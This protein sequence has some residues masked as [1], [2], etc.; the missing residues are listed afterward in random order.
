[1]SRTKS[2]DFYVENSTGY[3]IYNSRLFRGMNNR[4][5]GPAYIHFFQ[6]L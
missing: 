5:I 1:M 3:A 6:K 2:N 4:C